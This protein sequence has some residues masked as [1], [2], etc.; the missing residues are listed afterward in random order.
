[1][2]NLHGV[3]SELEQVYTCSECVMCEQLRPHQV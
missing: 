3:R 1:M 2:M